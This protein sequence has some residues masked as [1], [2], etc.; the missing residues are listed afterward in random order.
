MEKVK[1]MPNKV[2]KVSLRHLPSFLSY[3]KIREGVN[4]APPQAGCVL[5][6]LIIR[7]ANYEEKFLYRENKRK[8]LSLSMIAIANNIFPIPMP[9]IFNGRSHP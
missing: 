2:L 5:K 7:Q 1:L 4:S 6:W 8:L 9:Y 3:R